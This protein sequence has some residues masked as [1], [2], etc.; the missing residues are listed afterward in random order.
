[1]GGNAVEVRLQY[2]Q[3]V[4]GIDF[5]AAPL[6]AARA[7]ADQRG[8]RAEF[9]EMNALQ[10][11]DLGRV[12]DSVID[13]GLFHVFSDADRLLYVDGLGHATI[14]GGR[15]FLMCFSDEEQPGPGPRRVSRSE[16]RQAFSDG[17]SVES[18]AAARFEPNP[19]VDQSEFSEGGPKAW[20]AVIRRHAT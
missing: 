20:F 2:R 14:P 5:V 10:L 9:R 12:F 6:E 3:A 19:E 1:M 17:W 7:K 18:I 4:L 15:V 13:C 11:Q 16:L 8:L